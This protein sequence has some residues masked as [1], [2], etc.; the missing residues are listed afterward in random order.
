M[1]G[2]RACGLGVVVVALV[3]L[4]LAST[5]GASTIFFTHSSSLNFDGGSIW[6]VKSDGSGARQL[7]GRLPEGPGGVVASLSRD[8][9]HLFCLCHGNEI[10][11]MKLD[12]SGFKKVGN[13]PTRIK[14]DYTVLGPEGEPFW[15]QGSGLMTASRDGKHERPVVKGPFEEELA[16]PR[17]GRRIAVGGY[18]TLFTASLD[19][20]PVTKIYHSAFPGF[21][22]IGGMSWSAD[23][24]KLVFVDYPEPEEKYETAQE[25]EAH[26]YLYA[27]GA[28]RELPL[29]Q[30]AIY[31]PPI[32]SPDGSRLA[33][34]DDEGS[35]YLDSLGG[36]P[37]K[38]ILK[39]KCSETC[40]F[41]TRLLGWVR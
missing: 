22:G 28:V 34:T 13:R 21:R 11:S 35:I 37:A 15:F 25:P 1:K 24:R 23:G 30:E 18:D 2:L 7:R 40:F 39:K 20:G 9:K 32:F 36:A 33:S 26:V 12:G 16:I 38:R 3:A 6:S 19:G 27:D 17:Q 4:A 10:D 8:G 14:Y 31:G 5:A 41:G 29:G